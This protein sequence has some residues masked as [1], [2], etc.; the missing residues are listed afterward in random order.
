[1][2]HVDNDDLFKG[3][4]LEQIK[5]KINAKPKHIPDTVLDTAAMH[6]AIDRFQAEKQAKE[7]REWLV[8]EAPPGI[9]EMY[10]EEKKKLEEQ[11]AARI[12]SGNFFAGTF[13]LIL[14]SFIFYNLY[15]L[16]HIANPR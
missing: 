16:S 11:E 2:H 10:Q 7:I 8:Y 6:A 1:M 4:T 15:Q 13:I 9:Y 14:L 12:K 3:M 5:E